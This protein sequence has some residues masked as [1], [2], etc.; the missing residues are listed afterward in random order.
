MKRIQCTIF[1]AILV[2]ALCAPFANASDF[3]TPVYALGVDELASIP[4]IVGE[5]NATQKQTGDSDLGSDLGYTYES[6]TVSDDMRAYINYLYDMGFAVERSSTLSEPGEGELVALS[7]DPGFLLR[8]RLNWAEGEYSFY[9][10]KY[11][12][13]LINQ[14]DREVT[15]VEKQGKEA[16][17]AESFEES[18]GIFDAALSDRPDIAAYHGG[19][20]EALV[21][22]SRYEEA[23]DSLNTAI[24]LDP[25]IWRFYNERGMAYFYRGQMEEAQSD[26][27]KTMSLGADDPVAFCNLA[28]V[29]YWEMGNPEGAQ[30]TCIYGLSAF[31]DSDYLWLTLGN[32]NYS[33]GYHE[34]A[35]YAYDKAL[36]LG[37]Y[38]V[39][40]IEVYDEVRHKAN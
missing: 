9:F 34:A 23:I 38:T 20:G 35:L 11:K 26:F 19:R 21:C 12:R 27:W 22:L 32:V 33:M 28:H 24:Q 17:E 31:P 15:D 39:E 2:L 18:L 25:E 14:P 6:D 37:N 10:Q 4:A 16:M 40:D 3:S 1:A 13:T 5:R 7:K 30:L 36:S 29:Q 8:M